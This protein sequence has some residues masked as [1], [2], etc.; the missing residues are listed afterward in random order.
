MYWIMALAM[1]VF[2]VTLNI[3]LFWGLF[4][5]AMAT[6]FLYKRPAPKGDPPPAAS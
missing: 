1:A 5:V 3:R 2:A 6:A 4:A